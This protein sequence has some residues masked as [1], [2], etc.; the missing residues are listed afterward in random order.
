MQEDVKM[1]NYGLVKEMSAEFIGTFI[2]VFFGVGSVCVSV[3]LGAYGLWVVSLM[4]AL[5]VTLGVYAAGKVSGGHLNPAVTI[6]MATF[7]EFSWSKVLLYIVAQVLAAFLAAAFIY[8]LYSDI[9]AAF[10]VG[11]GLVRGEPGSQLSGMGYATYAPNPAFIGTDPAALSKVS[12]TQWFVSE[13]FATAILL[14]GIFYLLDEDNTLAPQ[15]NLAPVMI[16]LLVAA[17]VAFEA[18]ISMTALNP[19]R[20]LGPR[21]WMA[22][23]GWGDI[24][25]PGPRGGWWVPTVSTIIGG[26]AGGAL[27][28]CAYKRVFQA[29]Q[30]S[31]ES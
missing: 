18:P 8:Y 4:F 31:Q 15:A 16:G 22:I 25:F 26:L 19:A 17:L 2:L 20:D 12:L 1:S 5:G 13:A 23:V 11:K 9:L 3:W 29:S 10:E 28:Q 30:P 21:A 14:F 7:T 27:Y 24:A 6:T